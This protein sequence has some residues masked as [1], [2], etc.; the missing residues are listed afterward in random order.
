MQKHFHIMKKHLKSGE[1]LFLQIIRVWLNFTT[2][3]EG[4]ITAWASARKHFHIWQRSLPPNHPNLQ[5]VKRTI[6]MVK[7]KL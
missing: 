7:E 5:M 2:T 1:K 3:S 4:C 6:E